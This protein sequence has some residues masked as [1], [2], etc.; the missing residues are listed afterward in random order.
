MGLLN[1]K[2]RL[3][4]TILTDEGR[5]QLGAG[6]FVPVFYSF[7]DSSAVYSPGDTN[8]TGS[9][10]DQTLSTIVTFEAF[11]LPQDQV[12]YEAD[13]SG[14]LNV[15]GNNNIFSSSQGPVRV[16][17]GQLVKGWETGT[18]QILSSSA[19]FASTA[20]GIVADA[21]NNFRKLMILKSPDLLH[22]N[23]DEFILNK[24]RIDFRVDDNTTLPGWVTVG[25]LEATENLFF[26][27]RLSHVDNFKFLPPVNK[28]TNIPVGNYAG[29][30]A[31]N[32][33]ILTYEDL[34]AEFQNTV[35]NDGTVQRRVPLQR[36]TIYFSETSITNRLMG[37]VFEIANGKMS[38]LDVVDFGVFTI[39]KTDPPLFPDAVPV[40][41]NPDII[42]STTR[43]HVYFVGK[44]MLDATGS[45]KFLQ[46]F[47][48]V[49][50]V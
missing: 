1:Q 32:R 44:V 49:F 43:I 38:K 31:G 3:L 5:R 26:D 16:I 19:E 34:R 14:A 13:D 46:M 39:K 6:K 30:I 4:D 9:S 37:Q 36:D 27:R 15:V 45:E 42:A 35:V 2:Q 7:G 21:A 23:R 48:L 17:S 20:E 29:S 33:Q 10:P 50:Q 8:V 28:E 11:A 22:S 25:N 40:P 12:A 18:P 47:T 24:N 41:L